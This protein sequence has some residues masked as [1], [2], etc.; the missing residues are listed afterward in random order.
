[1]KNNKKTLTS[2]IAL[3]AIV[4]TFGIAAYTNAN[5]TYFGLNQEQREAMEQAVEDGDYNTWKSIQDSKTKITDIITKE[6]FAKFSEMHNL[7]QAGKID[8][9][10]VL[11]DELGLPTRGRR[12][13]RGDKMI[14][15]V[16]NETGKSFDA[17]RD[18]IEN[19]N[20]NAW[21]EAI[22][23]AR[24]SEVIQNEEDFNK[25]VEAHN[26]ILAGKYDEAKA[27]NDE[28]GVSSWGSTR[29]EGFGIHREVMGGKWFGKI[30][31]EA[32]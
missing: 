6:N 2:I 8:E 26:L 12:M 10:N 11:S 7:I 22:G 19:N 27:I 15:R 23:D 20:Y 30:H 28:L 13:G 5:F 21:K 31:Q 18:A 1:M 29:G 9:A 16:N 14:N 25:L 24:I 3:S 32:N 17:V 4:A